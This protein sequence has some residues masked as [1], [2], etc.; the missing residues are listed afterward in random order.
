MPI[1]TYRY[2]TEAL[3]LDN[4]TRRLDRGTPRPGKLSADY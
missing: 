2:V 3:P 4:V 1:V